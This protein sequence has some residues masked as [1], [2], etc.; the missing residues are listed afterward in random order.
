MIEFAISLDDLPG[1]KTAAELYVM[2]VVFANN[3]GG[4]WD[5]GK[6]GAYNPDADT[7]I[8]EDYYASNVYDI[9]GQAPTWEEVYGGWSNGDY[10]V[11]YYVKI[12]LQGG[13]IDSFF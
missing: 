6:N 4:I 8:T 12:Q 2:A 7:Y 11:N 13:K 3:Y 5:P 1:L 10:T 9:F